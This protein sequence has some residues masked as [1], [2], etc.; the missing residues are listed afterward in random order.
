MN[1]RPTQVDDRPTLVSLGFWGLSCLGAAALVLAQYLRPSPLGKPYVL[2]VSHYLGYALAYE[3]LGLSLLCAPFVLALRF[4]LAVRRASWLLAGQ[5]LLLGVSLFL[6]QWNHETQRFMGT[7]LSLDQL[8]TY[9]RVDKTPEVIWR[10]LRDDLGGAWSALWWVLCVPAF[11]ISAAWL[12]RRVTVGPRPRRRV[13]LLLALPMLGVLA[14]T[15]WLLAPGGG[16][17]KTK[18][19]P[20]VVLLWQSL[21]AERRDPQRFAN[22]QSAVRSVQAEWLAADGTGRHDFPDA[23]YPLRHA[24]LVQDAAVSGAYPNVLVLSL[25]TFRAGDM[26]SFNP[27]ARRAPTPFLDALAQDANSARYLRY[28][29]NGIPTVYAFLAMHT[30]TL[31]HSHLT[32]ARVFTHT[33]LDAFPQVARERGYTTLFFTGSDPDWDNQ[34][35]WLDRWYDE[36]DYDPRDREHDRV[37]FRR[38][39]KRIVQA[40]RS[41]KPF[42]AMLCS[43]TNHMPFRTPEPGLRVSDGDTMIDRLHDTMRYTDDVVRELFETLR[44][45]P[46]FDNTIVVVTGDHG[47]DLGDRGQQQGHTNLHHESIWVPLI[48]HGKDARLPRGAQTRPASHLDLAPTLTELMGH[49]GPVAFLGHSLLS[50]VRP[51][52]IQVAISDRH[53]GIESDAHTAYFPADGPGKLY[54]ADDVA[55]RVDLAPSQPEVL[56]ALRKR[57]LDWSLVNDWAFEHDR[58]APRSR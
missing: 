39:A 50:P 16:H 47:Y 31:P 38:A 37:L 18:L 6:S 22:V 40:G 19:R 11:W 36:V 15:A 2:D 28:I 52:A 23:T 48:V 12:A 9:G 25:E 29:A 17:R 24:P 53:I 51:S 58:F 4:E 35:F 21:V 1:R 34:R 41:G 56:Q 8:G 54:S 44:R 33:T 45:E 57:A 10:A 27:H 3:L 26:A 43:I 32:A 55:Q 30:S 7:Q 14:P 13:A 46:W 20:P 5:A 42:L 49:H